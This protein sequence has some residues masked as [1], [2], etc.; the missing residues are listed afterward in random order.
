MII[1]LGIGMSHYK[2]IIINHYFEPFFFL[3]VLGPKNGS[4]RF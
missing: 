1:L 3:A 2:K 4:N